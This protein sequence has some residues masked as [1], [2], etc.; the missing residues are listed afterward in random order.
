MKVVVEGVEYELKNV[1]KMT[2]RNLMALGEQSEAEGGRITPGK[3]EAMQANIRACKTNAE[4]EDHPDSLWLLA[5]MLWDGFR[6][7]GQPRTWSQVIDLNLPE[8]EYVF[9]DAELK[10]A[11]EAEPNPTTPPRPIKASGAGVRQPQDR[12]RKTSKA[13][14]SAG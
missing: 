10:V 7:A 5:V 2:V 13:K 6:E 12:A 8:I 4:R 14:S 9:T 11:A 3:V 1:L